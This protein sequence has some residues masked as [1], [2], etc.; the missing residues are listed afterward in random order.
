MF[1]ASNFR[2]NPLA[3]AVAGLL[4]APLA[5]LAAEPVVLPF[6]T[7]AAFF[8]AETKQARPIDPQVFVK[9]DKVPAAVGPQGIKHVA[10][11]RPAFIKDDAGSSAL[12]NA[13]GMPMGF[14][15]D[16]WLA[17]AGIVE[18]TPSGTGAILKLQFQHLRPNATYS[19]FEN[20]FDQAP[21]GFTPLDGVGS[22]NSFKT[23]GSGE[24]IATIVA[25]QPLSHA[26]AVLVVYDDDGQTH[27]TGRGDV[28][29]NAQH[30]LIARPAG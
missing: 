9:S 7:H 27:G 15:L 30:Q 18:M 28:G 11:F 16:E 1:S 23:D 12:F 3:L 17:P 21:V 2:F 25:T 26:N 10:G 4:Q 14:T 8:S 22:K 13:D 29:I 6:Q 19:V 20:H 24:A 5:V